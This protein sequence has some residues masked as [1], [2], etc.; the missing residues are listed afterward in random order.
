MSNRIRLTCGVLAVSNAFLLGFR[1]I[2]GN[3]GATV[4]VP[5]WIAG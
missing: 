2:V 3:R 4:V 5:D 1:V